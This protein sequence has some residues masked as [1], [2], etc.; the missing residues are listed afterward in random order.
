MDKSF[1]HNMALSRGREVLSHKS[2]DDAIQMRP[3]FA[4]GHSR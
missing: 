3:P 2:G 4:G 1:A